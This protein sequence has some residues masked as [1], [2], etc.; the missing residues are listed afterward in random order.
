MQL[1]G[2][3]KSRFACSS[4]KQNYHL[5]DH[6]VLRLNILYLYITNVVG[7]DRVIGK[8]NAPDDSSDD[9]TKVK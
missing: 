4:S 5:I 8:L 1:F 6:A 3:F 9:T 7:F 2:Y